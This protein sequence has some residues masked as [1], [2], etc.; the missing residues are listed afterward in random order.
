MV[1]GLCLKILFRQDAEDD[2]FDDV[3]YTDEVV[4]ALQETLDKYH[5]YLPSACATLGSWKVGFVPL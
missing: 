4:D 2:T 3:Q 5:A 1:H